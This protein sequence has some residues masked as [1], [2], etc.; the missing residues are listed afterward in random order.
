VS[1]PDEM[2]TNVSEELGGGKLS[3]VLTTSKCIL[4]W[5][6]SIIGNLDPPTLA[7]GVVVEIDI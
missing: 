4:S 5:G 3:I 1:N 7:H 6:S 2:T